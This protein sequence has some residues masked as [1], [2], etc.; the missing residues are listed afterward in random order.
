MKLK[1]EK[2]GD[3]WY[4]YYPLYIY[5]TREKFSKGKTK[6]EA[7]SRAGKKLR[8]MLRAERMYWAQVFKN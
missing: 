7:E 4:S 3:L 5:W 6:G 1:T 2:I 8:S